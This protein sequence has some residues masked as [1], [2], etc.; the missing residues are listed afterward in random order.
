MG[1][2]HAGKY[3]SQW[4]TTA[5]ASD[6]SSTVAAAGDRTARAILPNCRAYETALDDVWLRLVSARLSRRDGEFPHG[7]PR[8]ANSDHRADTG[9]ENGRLHLRK[10]RSCRGA[11]CAD[12]QSV[13]C[14]RV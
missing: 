8:R 14:V 4:E 10:R 13:R 3:D 2:L 7:K 11:S 1:R 9:Q 6:L 5:Q 12:V